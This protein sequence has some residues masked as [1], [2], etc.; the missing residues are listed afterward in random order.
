MTLFAYEHAAPQGSPERSFLDTIAAL[1][2]RGLP[3]NRAL[4]SRNGR[5]VLCYTV[6]P[7]TLMIVEDH[8]SYNDASS[9]GVVLGAELC[10]GRLVAHTAA[11]PDE[12]SPSPLETLSTARTILAEQ[13]VRDAVS[14]EGRAQAMGYIGMRAEEFQPRQGQLVVH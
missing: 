10:E 2:D 1:R 11:Y 9:G 5:G 14:P 8:S 4:A 3:R 6:E 13:S 12:L 7:P